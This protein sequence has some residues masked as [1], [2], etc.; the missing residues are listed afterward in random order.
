MV[1]MTSSNYFHDQVDCAF[2][3]YIDV[4]KR[5]SLLINTSVTLMTLG[6]EGRRDWPGNVGTWKALPCHL[7]LQQGAESIGALWRN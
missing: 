7:V 1:A 4:T 2:I 5:A 3:H 6:V